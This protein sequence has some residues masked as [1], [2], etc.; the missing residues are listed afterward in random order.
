MFRVFEFLFFFF[1]VVSRK[2]LFASFLKT[3]KEENTRDAK[4][5]G[6]RNKAS[7]FCFYTRAPYRKGYHTTTKDKAPRTPKPKN[8]TH[9]DDDDDDD[10]DDD[11]TTDDDDDDKSDVRGESETRNTPPPPPRRRRRRKERRRGQKK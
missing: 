1:L 6:D 5:K 8:T 3:K 10:D 2:S 11:G 9:V 7:F 4:T